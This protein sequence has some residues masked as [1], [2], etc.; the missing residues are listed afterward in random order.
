MSDNSNK[1]DTAPI[2]SQYYDFSTLSPQKDDINFFELITVILNSKFNREKLVTHLKE[3]EIQS[4]SHYVP[5]HS[6][7]AGQKFG[8]THGDMKHTDAI[9]SQL[10][11]LPMWS[12]FTDVAK[13]V[14]ALEDF[15]KKH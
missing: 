13:V 6:S 4:D 14:S 5:L 7:T 12:G 3:N 8:R 10:L 2:K 1:N 15:F 11:R 9:A